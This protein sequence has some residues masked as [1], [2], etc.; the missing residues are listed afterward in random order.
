MKTNPL[1]LIDGYKAD[2][3]RQYPVGTELV[4]SNFTPR[5]TRHA[6]KV[7]GVD[8]KVVFFGLQYLLK[9]LLVDTFNQEFFNQ[10][11]EKVVK[12][13]KR[14]LDNYLG[15]GA[16][17]I[18]HIEELHDLGHLPISIRALPEGAVV[19]EKVPVF[20]IENTKPGAFWLTNY[21]ETILSNMIWKPCTS[22]T[23][24]RK[25]RILLKRYAKL[26]GADVNFVDF[27]AHDFSFRG[28]SSP[29]DAVMSGAAHLAAGN[30]GT[31]TIPAIDLLEDYYNANS[32]KEL[33]GCSVPATEHSVMCAGG[34]GDEL[35]T[36]KRL[37]TELYPQ[38]IV[39]IVSDTWDF[40]QVVTVF[41]PALKNE[42][43]TRKGG[44]VGDKVVIRPDS[45]DPVRIICGYTEDEIIRNGSKI[46]VRPT[47]ETATPN[48]S[49]LTEI[50]E[51]EFK[52]A[53]QCLWDTF[54][55]TVTEK[56]FK[57]LDPHIGLIY[58]DSITL[59]RCYQIMEGLMKKGFASTNVV[60]GVGSYTYQY[61]TR[62]TLGFAMKATSVT[63]N[64]EERAIFKDPKTDGGMKKSAKGYL[65][66][67]KNDNGDYVLHD[68]VTK[69]V[70]DNCELKE[71]FRDGKL[72]IDYTLA[73]IR[74]R[75]NESIEKS[76]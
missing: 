48:T 34:K 60:L 66:V 37:I 30:L 6:P 26:T 9:W 14:R 12:Q 54:G 58:G 44:P 63:V 53:I 42:I 22:A 52:G 29:Q 11:K 33:V 38:G 64:G 39:S 70:A 71:V 57:V 69:V 35:Y 7:K 15:P 61:C 27:Q 32:D 43:L 47:K 50:T 1:N 40:W 4:Y 25:Y 18:E 24:A 31:D 55:G 23:T 76:L 72:L 56:G 2:H 65:A 21:L 49:A 68:E 20:V 59:E 13:Y 73:D 3:R 5:S 10:P 46:Y 51:A 67:F 17:P 62:D 16:V 45:G 41:L 75:V 8:N 36:F 28:M 74:K 19:D